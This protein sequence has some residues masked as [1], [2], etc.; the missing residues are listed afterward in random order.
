M[1]HPRGGA[2]RRCALEPAAALALA[3][4]AGALPPPAAGGGPGAAAPAWLHLG[5]VVRSNLG[6]AGP[7]FGRAPSLRYG[8]VAVVGGESVDLDISVQ[9][10]GSKYAAVSPERNGLQGHVGRVNV[11]A[12]T[13][14]NLLFNFVAHDTSLPK[15]LDNFFVT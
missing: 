9:G 6:G 1:R 11:Q 12:G 13:G 14:V 7:D 15:K 3:A 8:N 10:D 2:R 5:Q 4:A